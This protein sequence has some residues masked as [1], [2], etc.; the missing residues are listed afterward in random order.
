MLKNIIKNLKLRFFGFVQGTARYWCAGLEIHIH[1]F[2]VSL[3]SSRSG[4]FALT[5]TLN[6]FTSMYLSKEMIGSVAESQAGYR[7]ETLTEIPNIGDPSEVF[8]SVTSSGTVN[9]KNRIYGDT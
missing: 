9:R 3:P 4:S 2:Y 5:R 6:I 8:K 1:T 7:D